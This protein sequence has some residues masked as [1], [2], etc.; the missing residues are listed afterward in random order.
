MGFLRRAL[1]LGVMLCWAMPGAA[2][3]FEARMSGIYTAGEDFDFPVQMVIWPD[4][5]GDGF[6]GSVTI[7]GARYPLYAER[8]GAALR[9]IF[10]AEGAVQRFAFLPPEEGVA[11][12][13][14]TGERAPVAMTRAALP[15]F[16]AR[17]EGPFGSLSLRLRDGAVQAV[18]SDESGAQETW[19]GRQLGLRVLF[20]DG[21]ASVLYEPGNNVY[22]LEMPG[23]F[24]AVEALPLP[25]VVGTS[26]SA[27]VASLEAALAQVEPGGRIEIEPGQY[28]GSWNVSVPVEIVGLGG[29][30]DKVVLKAD[31]ETGMQWSADQGLLEG[32]TMRMT[33]TGTALAVQGGML[34]IRDSVIEVTGGR[35]VALGGSARLEIRDSKLRGGDHAITASDFAGLLQVSNS[36]LSDTRKSIVTLSGAADGKARIEFTGNTLGGSPSNAFRLIDGVSAYLFENQIRDVRVGFHQTNAGAAEFEQNL[37]SGIGTHAIW[38][39][40]VVRDGPLRL[41]GNG[42]ADVGEA[43]LLFYNFQPRSASA[44]VTN[45]SFQDCGKFGL[46]IVG[47]ETDMDKHRLRIKDG[48]FEQNGTHIFLNGA[49]QAVGSGLDMIKARGSAIVLSETSSFELR[50][51]RIDTTPDHGLMAIGPG[52][53]ATL[54]ETEIANAGKSGAVFSGG[55]LGSFERVQI[56]QS[57]VHGI[58][59]HSGSQISRFEGNLVENNGG[60]GVWVDGTFFVPGANNGFIENAKGD[61]LRD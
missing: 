58:E 25:I 11:Q 59:L 20:S 16:R 61:I 39:E 34:A 42:I 21:P 43:C 33:E 49:A 44:E 35:G 12:V 7:S 10:E 51:S 30:P 55:A 15:G 14:F 57:T 18:F 29:A 19:Q 6:G 46:A 28:A 36:D 8:D 26:G 60:A 52:V 23:F 53:V 40:G 3:E 4:P 9:G 47:K 54:I 56:R 50:E 32:L 38:I 27:D 17:F 22:Y 37:F 2:Q 31:G 24:G 48:H 13:E 5:E 41:T 1:A 45:N